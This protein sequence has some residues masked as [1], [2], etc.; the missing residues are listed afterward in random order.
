MVSPPLLCR[1][2]LLGEHRELHALVGIIRRGTALSGY[3]KK[4]LIETAQISNRH[5]ALVVEML[6]RGYQHNS[7]LTPEITNG[8][9]SVDV[10]YNLAEL[11]TRCTGCKERID[12][13][14]RPAIGDRVR[15]TGVMDDPD[16]LPIGLEGTVDYLTPVDYTLQQYGVKWDNKRT[17][18]LLPHDPYV[19]L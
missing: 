1:Q 2:H 13:M 17:L 5:E 8:V 6:A 7:P 12:T 9:G 10:A 11:R 19:I 16:P 18:F 15:I 4:H 14:T 3:V